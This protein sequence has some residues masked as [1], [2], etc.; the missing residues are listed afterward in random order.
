MLLRLYLIILLSS[1]LAG[2]LPAIF[3]GATATTLAVA[4][5]R[6]IGETVDDVKIA[7]GIK[8]EFIKSKF[9][10]LY[11]KI[12]VDVMQGRVLYTGTVDKEEDIATAVDIAWK[13]AGV[14]E[15]IDELK[16][17]EKSNH[18]NPVQYTKDTLITGQIK[19]KLFANRDIKFINYT[20]VTI[21]SVVYLF[22]TAKNQEE[23]EKAANIASRVNGVEKVVSHV[24]L[25]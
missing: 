2:C 20:V 10:E 17:D 23:L 18:F 21:N 5:D 8:T 11:A 22:G 3:A 15:V 16:V 13:Q 7:T 19:G 14:K 4:K 24:K 1:S 25:R 6:T 12:H 9:Q